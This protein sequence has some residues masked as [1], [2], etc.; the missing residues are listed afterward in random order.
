MEEGQEI[1]IPTV[2]IPVGVLQSAIYNANRQ[3]N[4]LSLKE[5][6]GN[7]S[8]VGFGR[9]DHSKY[10]ISCYRTVVNTGIIDKQF[11]MSLDG[12]IRPINEKTNE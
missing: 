3:R 11:L 1:I 10:Q 7:F 12:T 4:K 5:L 6:Y 9:I 2:I 8:S